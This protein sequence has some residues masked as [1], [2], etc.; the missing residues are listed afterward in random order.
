M[1]RGHAVADLADLKAEPLSCPGQSRRFET[2][3]AFTF[4][5]SALSTAAGGIDKWFAPANP[6][7]GLTGLRFL[8]QRN[9]I[10]ST[11]AASAANAAFFS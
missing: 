9:D 8:P 6:V 4:A 7:K 11:C 1:P 5:L 10:R 2:Q 3:S